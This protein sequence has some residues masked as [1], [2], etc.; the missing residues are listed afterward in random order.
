MSALA[1]SQ[2]QADTTRNNLEHPPGY[3]TSEAGA[4]PE[5]IKAGRG[6]KVLIIIPGLGFDAS[7][8][9]DFIRE[10]K[11][12]YTMYVVTLPGFGKTPAP[13][14]PR[15]GTSYG[16]QTWC[17]GAAQG[18]TRLIQREKLR[19]PIIVGHFVTG[20]QVAIR[21]AAEN[22]DNVGGLLILG[23]SAK[24]MATLQGKLREAPEAEMVKGTD[25]YW[26]P[27]WFKHMTKEFYDKGNFAPE[28]YSA[29]AETAA[30]LWGQVAAVP[31]PVSVRYACEY[32]ATDMLAMIDRV[33]SPILVVRPMFTAKFWENEMNKN[34]IQPQFIESW[35][36]AAKRNPSVK[37]LDVEA[38]AAFVWED[39][40]EMVYPA[41]ERFVSSLKP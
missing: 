25:T 32:Y 24:M 5:Y 19:K 23:G 37:L 20:T 36:L 6:K 29:K 12:K 38:A 26:A 35:N 33:T 1:Q 15:K 8:F 7:V 39:N 41:I 31:M 27:K 21:L 10:N 18:I 4:V 3:V 28:V 17:K 30:S 14:M 2:A 34:W 11:R 13:P 40:P 9:S 16:E 22:P